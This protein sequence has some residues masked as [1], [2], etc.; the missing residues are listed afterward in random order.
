MER[1]FD[2]Q[3]EKLK[4][5]L[6]KMCSLVDEQ[7][8][9]VIKAVLEH[10]HALAGQIAEKDDTIDKYDVKIEKICQKLFALNQPV[11]MDLRL[12]MSALKINSNLERVGDLTVII[13]HNIKELN[14]KPAFFDNLNFEETARKSQEMIKKAIDSFIYNDPNLARAVMGMDDKL[15]YAVKNASSQI[16][17]IMKESPDNVEAGMIYHRIFQEI[18]GIG[19]HAA[20]ICE[21]VYFIVK[22]RTLKHEF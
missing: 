1:P 4:T 12:V 14:E 13:S 7:V 16:L 20:N 21:E 2:I 22:A 10:D 3:L 6:I 5:K 18:E 9:L 11:A 15:D 17:S 8:E 19:D